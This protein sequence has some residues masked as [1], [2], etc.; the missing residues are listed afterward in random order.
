LLQAR[1]AHAGERL[2][3]SGRRRDRSDEPIVVERPLQTKVRGISIPLRRNREAYRIVRVDDATN[4]PS[5]ADSADE[6]TNE[7]FVAGR[8]YLEPRRI[9][10]VRAL[11]AKIPTPDHSRLTI[12]LRRRDARQRQQGGGRDHGQS[13]SGHGDFISVRG[14]APKNVMRRSSWA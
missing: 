5:A 9:R 11:D 14:L 8:G 12:T 1:C 4:R 2:S 6:P 3:R 10:A 13:R 7:Y